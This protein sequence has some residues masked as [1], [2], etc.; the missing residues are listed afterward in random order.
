MIRDAIQS[1]LARGMYYRRLLGFGIIV[2]CIPILLAA[3]LTYAIVSDHLE[4]QVNRANL[5]MIEQIQERVDGAL[6]SISKSSRGITLDPGMQQ[7]LYRTDRR[8]FVE[9]V[10][11]LDKLTAASRSIEFTNTVNLFLPEEKFVLSSEKGYQKFDAMRDSYPFL[12]AVGAM[13]KPKWMMLKKGSLDVITFVQPLP[14]FTDT[15]RAYLTVEVDESS[16]HSV[17]GAVERFD[18]GS[19]MLLDETGVVVSHN[20]KSQLG[21]IFG[22]DLE[23][24]KQKLDANG[25]SGFFNYAKAGFYTVYAKSDMNGWMTVLNIPLSVMASPKNQVA[26]TTVLVCL[27]ALIL[28]MLLIYL[29]SRKLYA[30]IRN[31]L[32]QEAGVPSA[33]GGTK[34]DEWALI[35]DHWGNLKNQ[36]GQYHDVSS[37]QTLS[38]RE[39]FMMQMIY[40]YYD[41]EQPERIRE[42]ALQY[43]IQADAWWDVILIEPENYEQYSRFKKD[44]KHLIL[45]AI[46]SIFQ[47]LMKQHN[48]NGYFVF[49]QDAVRLIVVVQV[50]IE[51]KAT[52]CRTVFNQLAESVRLSVNT[53]LKFDCSIGIG[54]VCDHIDGIR[55][56]YL[57]AEEALATRITAG[58]NQTIAFADLSA[59]R[60]ELIYPYE[61]E[62]SL[63]QELQ[64]GNREGFGHYFEQFVQVVTKCNYP[65][66]SVYESFYALFVQLRRKAQELSPEQARVLSGVDAMKHI[67]SCRMIGDMVRWFEEKVFP[68]LL[69]LFEDAIDDRGKVI[70][71]AAKSYVQ[72]RLDLDHSLTSMAEYTGVSAAYFSRLFNKHTGHNFIQYI[73]ELKVERSKELLL[74]TDTMI[75]EIALQVGYND[76]T[77][78]RVFKKMTGYSPANFRNQQ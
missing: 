36:I 33:R 57:E 67:V 7:Y 8:D 23:G 11:V 51:T 58:G 31:L 55:Q 6:K 17:L 77:F 1:V 16:F 26:Q 20:D 72:E 48:V 24:W 65:V 73:A 2:L 4:R 37:K 35:Q 43:E 78:R 28:G 21:S 54:A 62:H 69:P 50:P 47:D 61:I 56:C 39:S 42:M 53:Y 5:E 19:L 13:S 64:K 22:G 32:R 10:D 38:L 66:S 45:L 34:L 30:P 27:G 25:R 12:N 18:R 49:G 3:F 41:N 71:E 63:I 76:R 68:V 59:F 44:D 15:P 46:S 74:N 75:S 29:N 40:G 14:I 60:H 9:M 70:I 52:Q